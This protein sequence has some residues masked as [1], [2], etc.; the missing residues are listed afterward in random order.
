MQ[1]FSDVLFFELIA[2][3]LFSEPIVIQFNIK[4][5][6]NFWIFAYFVS[7][8]LLTGYCVYVQGRL[9]DVSYNGIR[10]SGFPSFQRPE[11]TWNV[12]CV[13]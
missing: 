6:Y 3:I 8:H 12:T 13:N 11:V 4:N 1:C 9:N 2:V 10:Y 5:K 7:G